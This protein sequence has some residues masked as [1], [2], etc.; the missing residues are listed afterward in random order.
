MNSVPAGKAGEENSG[1]AQSAPVKKVFMSTGAVGI[2]STDVIIQPCDP[3]S[4][5]TDS[6]RS[7]EAGIVVSLG[8]IEGT[9]KLQSTVEGHMVGYSGAQLAG[10]LRL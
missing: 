5:P 3:N 7:E 9:S 4:P 1:F 8:K 6:L 2:I 10:T